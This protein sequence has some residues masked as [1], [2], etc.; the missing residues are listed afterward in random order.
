MKINKTIWFLLFLGIWEMIAQSGRFSPLIFPSRGAVL[1]AL[2][3]ALASGELLQETGFSIV[4]ILEGIL[5]GAV[6]ALFFGI[7]FSL[8]PLLKSFTEALVALAHP[9]P[10]IALLPVII[11]WL[12]TG[13]SSILFIIVHSVLWPLLLNIMAGFK[14]TPKVLREPG[15][16]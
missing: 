9:L 11:L 10:G 6:L 12:G 5:I 1:K 13:R 7:A 2:Y 4:L 3:H 14:A 16:P 8:S 15:E